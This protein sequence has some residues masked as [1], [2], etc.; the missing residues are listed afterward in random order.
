VS[1]W[2]DRIAGSLFSTRLDSSAL[3]NTYKFADAEVGNV[4]FDSSLFPTGAAGSMKIAC[5]NSAGSNNGSAMLPFG[6]DFTDGSVVWVSFRCYAP[7]AFCYQNWPDTLTTGVYSGNTAHKLAIISHTSQ[8]HP[9]DWEVVWQ[10]NYNRNMI[11]GYWD[12]SATPIEVGAVT[13]CSGTDFRQQPSIDNGA[14]LLTGTD[15]DTGSAWSSCQ[16]DDARYGPLYSAQSEA[17]FRRGFGFPLDRGVRQT[18]SNWM[19]LTCRVQIGNI[20]V[21]NSRLTMYAAKDGE[22]Y[23]KIADRT[24][25]TL[26]TAGDGP[27]NAIWLLPYTTSRIAGGRQISSRT[28]N[29]TGVTLHVC[30]LNTPIGDGTLEYVASTGLFRWKGFGEAYGTARGFSATNQKLI[31]N[32]IATGDSYVV[33]EITP[34]SLPGSGT[35]TDTV[36]IAADRPDTQIN[37]ADVI[38][39]TKPILAPGGFAPTVLGQ[40]VYDAVVGSYSTVTT[41]G[42]QAALTSTDNTDAAFNTSGSSASYGV[43]MAWDSVSQKFFYAGGDHY[44]AGAAQHCKWVVYDEIS[45]TW[46]GSYGTRPS[47]AGVVPH[48]YDQIALSEADRYFYCRYPYAGGAGD[49]QRYQIDTDTWDTLASNGTISYFQQEGALK[50]LPGYGLIHVL[51]EG[52]GAGTYPGAIYR[53]NEAT[54]TWSK[55]GANL[56]MGYND[57][58]ACYSP[59]AN[60]VFFGGGAN[61]GSDPEPLSFYKVNT[62]GTVTTLTDFPIGVSSAQNALLGASATLPYIYLWASDGSMRRYDINADT[63]TTIDAAATNHFAPVFSYPTYGSVLQCLLATCTTHGVI[64]IAKDNGASGAFYVFKDASALGSGGGGTILTLRPAIMT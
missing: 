49:I 14:S 44:G 40:A 27:F 11:G 61:L 56:D 29:I 25:I 22:A 4:T 31:L 16:Q 51:P 41:T 17:T 7:P 54:D 42:L 55:V 33:A 19:T 43:S 63:W 3:V 57:A 58:I 28:T 24:G 48:S 52:P 9:S 47:G 45:N 18:P 2:S 60:C 38:V 6:Q 59:V 32:I 64:C 10:C 26:G 35:T 15:P 34:G 53:W 37:Y 50:F 30:G 8:S 23:R 21:A 20:N 39:S 5:L 12:P 1:D 46:T 62:S 36:T 13:A